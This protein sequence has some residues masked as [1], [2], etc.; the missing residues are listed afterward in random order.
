LPAFRSHSC[1]VLFMKHCSRFI[2][3][4]HGHFTVSA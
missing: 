2:R 3:T 4:L 1:P